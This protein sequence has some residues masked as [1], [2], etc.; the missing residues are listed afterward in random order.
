MT[1]VIINVAM[2]TLDNNRLRYTEIGSNPR[3][4]FLLYAIYLMDN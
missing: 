3:Q 2:L 1:S 4:C